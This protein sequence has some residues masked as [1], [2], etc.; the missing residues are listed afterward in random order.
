LTFFN[1]LQLLK[2]RIKISLLTESG[3]AMEDLSVLLEGFNPAILKAISNTTLC[4]LD[5]VPSET[6]SLWETSTTTLPRLFESAECWNEKPP[7]STKLIL[8]TLD[9]IAD[10][11]TIITA[12]R[13]GEADTKVDPRVA[14]AQLHDP[15]ELHPISLIGFNLPSVP[16]TS[17]SA[18]PAL[19]EFVE[20][21]DE[22][23][24][25][26][27]LTPKYGFTDLHIDSAD[28]ISSPMG[29]CV[30]LWL[31]FPPTVQNL[32]LMASAEGQ[33]AKLVRIGRKLEGGLL[34]K[35]TSAESIYLP[36]G[37]IHSVITLHGG[38]LVAIDFNTP[39]SCY[40]FSALLSAGLDKV[41]SPSF[42]N[43]VFDRYLASVDL[44]LYNL[45]CVSGISS[46]I[47]SIERIRE[48]V[49]ES[50]AWAR[51]ATKV[52]DEFLATPRGRKTKCPCGKQTTKDKFQGHLKKRH[53]WGK[54]W[55]SVKKEKIRTRL[56]AKRA[57]KRKAEDD[58]EEK[59]TSKIL[60]KAKK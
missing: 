8:E 6:E 27:L 45:Q 7:E 33:K 28:G 39:K 31:V 17:F 4:T 52:W 50:P 12:F 58:L 48:W 3:A 24:L 32:K 16:D 53:W 14:I 59:E 54:V 13:R 26:L 60:K 38:F 1:S 55:T 49:E 42:Q 5:N 46:W 11:N 18:T 51:K 25:Q 40:A 21:H 10:P 44:A 23:N 47:D 37:C 56:D 30:K 41:G 43:E 20:P 19:S 15:K 2:F 29:L 22:R 57:V 36:V 34:F 35:T 9:A